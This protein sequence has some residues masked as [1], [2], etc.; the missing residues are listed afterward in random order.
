[1]GLIKKEGDGIEGK[2]QIGLVWRERERGFW[3]DN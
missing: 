1:M 3:S 2:R